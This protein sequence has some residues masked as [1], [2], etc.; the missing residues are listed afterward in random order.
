[1]FFF[2]TASLGKVPF[3]G[4]LAGGGGSCFILNAL[5]LELFGFGNDEEEYGG[6]RGDDSDDPEGETIPL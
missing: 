1:M 3:S 5:G 2:I 6:D 4:L